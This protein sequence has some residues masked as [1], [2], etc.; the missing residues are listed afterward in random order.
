MRLYKHHAE[1]IPKV[2]EHFQ[3]KPD[4]LALL[5]GGSLAHGRARPES[6]VD[7]LILV[8]EPAYEKRR[9]TGQPQFF[10]RGLCRHAGGYVDGKYL[11]PTFLRQVANAGSEQARF[12]FQDAQVLFSRVDGLDKLL[13]AIVGYPSTGKAERVRR[14]HAQFEAWYWYT[15]E[16]LKLANLYLLGAS[17]VAAF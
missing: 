3:A 10:N 4:V 16:A 13:R 8:T 11:R 2:V 14:F 17:L 15:H 6:D 7:V 12:A 5:L 9:R 1:S